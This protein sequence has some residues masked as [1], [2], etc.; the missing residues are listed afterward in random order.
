MKLIL[1]NWRQYLNEVEMGEPTKDIAYTAFVLDDNSKF[2]E[3]V[4]EG[5]ETHAHHMTILAVTDMKRRLPERWQ[6]YGHDEEACLKVV[7]IAKN[8]QV[9]AAR[10]DLEGLPI[11]MKIRGLPHITIATNPEAGG[12]PAMSN[13]FKE[14]DFVP[15]DALIVVCGK[16][17]EVSR[18]IS[19]KDVHDLANKLGIPWNN[20][21]DFMDW[22]EEVVGKSHL[23]DM[24]PEELKKVYKALEERGD[25]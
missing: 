5:W 25:E 22:T 1:E 8:D 16:V 4:P 19:K 9:V 12:K 7:G 11:P 15:L 2:L 23:D 18:P 21:T 6:S 14:E 10:V 20:D 17:E 24:T 13:K 3:Y